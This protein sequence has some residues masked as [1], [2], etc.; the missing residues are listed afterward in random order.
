MKDEGI[1]FYPKHGFSLFEDHWRGMM[2]GRIC[3]RAFAMRW[4]AKVGGVQYGSTT[5]PLPKHIVNIR[6][7]EQPGIFKPIDV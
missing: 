6:G 4:P 3:L 5:R 2:S 1:M 7:L